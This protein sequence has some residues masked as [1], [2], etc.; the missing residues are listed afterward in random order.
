MIFKE[1]KFQNLLFHYFKS[2]FAVFLC[3][4]T[5]ITALIY[6]TFSKNI[7]QEMITNDNTTFNNVNKLFENAIEDCERTYNALVA[8]NNII[9]FICNDIYVPDKVEYYNT[10]LSVKNTLISNQISSPYIKSITLISTKNDLA[11]SSDSTLPSAVK[12]YETLDFYKRITENRLDSDVTLQQMI[13]PGVANTNKQL[14]IAKNPHFLFDGGLI[15]FTIDQDTLKK[16]L[17]NILSSENEAYLFNNNILLSTEKKPEYSVSELNDMYNKSFENT[18]KC[19]DKSGN[20]T[21]FSSKIMPYSLKL[22]LMLDNSDY[23]ALTKKTIAIMLVVFI[24][25]ILITVYISYCLAKRTAKPVSEIIRIIDNP[26]MLSADIKISQLDEIKYITQNILK[27]LKDNE[28]YKSELQ[29]KLN[30]LKQAEES[31]LSNQI[32]PHFIF[33][34]LETIHAVT[35]DLTK[36]EN[37]STKMIKMLSELLQTSFRNDKKF[38]SIEEELKHVKNYLNLQKI[39]YSDLFDIKWDIDEK[40]LK[41]STI[42]FILQPICENAIYHGIKNADFFCYIKISIKEN[43]NTVVLTVENTGKTMDKTTVKEINKRLKENTDSSASHIGLKNVN[44]RIRIAFGEKYGCFVNSNEEKTTVTIT[45]P[46]SQIWKT[47]SHST[48]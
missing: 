45:I 31:S 47:D 32:K 13:L 8:N 42:K 6:T 25:T 37:K 46:K 22:L 4:F 11:L 20:F 17:S 36:C 1:K 18:N 30:E 16:D 26:K 10:I 39:R 48:I 34:T 12:Y 35:F 21:V 9:K 38:I 43:K 24:L 29:K 14:I 27:S 28:F 7:K 23:K 33:N 40:C 15:M 5:I 41:Y 19:T 3:V 44:K 2:F